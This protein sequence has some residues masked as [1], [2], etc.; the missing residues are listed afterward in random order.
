MLQ[1]FKDKIASLNIHKSI[2][3]EHIVNNNLI[4][5]TVLV[6]SV[7]I[8]NK[9]NSSTTATFNYKNK[10]AVKITHVTN[11]ESYPLFPSINPGS[12]NDAIIGLF[13]P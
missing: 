8:F 1:T 5:N 13:S 7:T 6:D 11:D 3:S 9:C 10:K 12:M 2:H 4:T